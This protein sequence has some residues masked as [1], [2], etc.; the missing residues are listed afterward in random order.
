M[1]YISL[2]PIF[3]GLLSSHVIDSAAAVQIV[4]QPVSV[5]S[6]SYHLQLNPSQ[7][8]IYSNTD[9]AILNRAIQ[10]SYQS[11]FPFK[12]SDGGQYDVKISVKSSSED[13]H[14]GV[15]ESYTLYLQIGQG[16]FADNFSSDPKLVVNFLSRI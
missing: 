6:G 4:P 3:I 7:F 8:K 9:S 5:Q 12:A 16:N 11:L 2:I 13:L 14:L 1:Y 10:R 15:D